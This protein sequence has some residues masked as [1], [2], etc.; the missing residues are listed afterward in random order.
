M[1]HDIIYWTLGILFDCLTVTHVLI[2][3]RELTLF[4]LYVTG[5]WRGESEAAGEAA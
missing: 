4:F 3:V 5:Q 2:D 1:L